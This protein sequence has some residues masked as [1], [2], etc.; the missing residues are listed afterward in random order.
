MQIEFH[1]IYQIQS[2]SGSFMRRSSGMNVSFVDLDGNVVGGRVAGPLVVASPAAVM[3]V[4]FLA[5]EQHEQKLN[6]QKN[7]VISTVTPTVAARMSSAGPML[8]N[9]SSSS[10]FHGDNQYRIPPSSGRY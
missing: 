9:L 2:L 5:S 10:C 1:G 4:T 6:T 3:V 7:E 8:N